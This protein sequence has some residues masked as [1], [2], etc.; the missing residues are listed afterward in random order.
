[1]HPMHITQFPGESDMER[2]RQAAAYLRGH[3]GTCLVLEPKTYHLCDEQARKLQQE[4]MAGAFTKNPEPLLFNYNFAYVSGI[5]LTGAQDVC[6]DGRGATLRFDGFMENFTLASCKNVTLKN[7][8]IDLVRKAYSK[9]IVTGC[10]ERWTDAD[11][12]TQ[13]MLCAAMP[14]MRILIYSPT[15]RRFVNRTVIGRDGSIGHSDFA[16]DDEKFSVEALGGGKFRLHGMRHGGIGDELYVTHTFHFRPSILIYEAEHT[17]LEHICIHSHCGMGVVG[18]RS[19]DILLR[20]LKIVPSPGEAMS[21]NTDATHFASCAGL[22]RFEG[23]HF[24]GHGDDATNVHGY[25]HTILSANKNSCTARV[26]APTGTH[27][28]KLDYFNPGDMLELTG[29]KNLASA[30]TYRVLESRPDF[31]KM[32]C[33]YV[34]DSDLPAELDAYFLASVTQM[35]RLEFIG[36]FVSSHRS[37]CVLVKTRDVLIENSHFE[38]TPHPAVCVSA[39]GWWHEGT[40]SENVVIRHNRMID[41]GGISINIA[42]DKPDRPAHKNILIENNIIDCPACQHAIRAEHVDGLTVR[43]NQVRCAEQGILVEHC[44]NVQLEAF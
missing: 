16:C 18:H 38:Q 32:Q 7:F 31:D 23:C 25:Y 29:I 10:G 41:C 26:E 43:G 40:T 33:E 14:T 2:F 22:L 39:E 30:K 44:E 24:A 4:V 13:T 34:L 1:M 12:G 17:V 42:A 9:G 6:I 8:N 21:T 37:R 11:F 27:S 20:G 5:D 15:Q 3:L 28:Q 19:K 36:C 35:P